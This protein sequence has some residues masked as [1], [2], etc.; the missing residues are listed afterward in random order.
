MWNEA[1]SIITLFFITGKSENILR[2]LT[3]LPKIV[4]GSEGRN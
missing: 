3:I 4:E 1:G 2:E